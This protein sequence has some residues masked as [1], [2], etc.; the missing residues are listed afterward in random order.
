MKRSKRRRFCSKTPTPSPTGAVRDRAGFFLVYTLYLLDENDLALETVEELS[1]DPSETYYPDFA[2]V[3]GE[4]Y[5]T[6]GDAGAAGEVLQRALNHH[7]AV[8]MEDPLVAQ[9]LYFLLGRAMESTDPASAAEYFDRAAKL[10]PT[11]AV[12]VEAASR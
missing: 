5:L 7:E 3:A 6:A 8:A 4:I 1:P 9:G 11:T 10:A 2:M 12:G